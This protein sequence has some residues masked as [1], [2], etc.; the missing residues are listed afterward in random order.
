VSGTR[1]DDHGVARALRPLALRDEH[2]IAARK[3]EHRIALANGALHGDE[4]P[5]GER[6]QDL[7]DP[8]LAARAVERLRDAEVAHGRL[9]RLAEIGGKRGLI[10]GAARGQQDGGDEEGECQHRVGEALRAHQPGREAL[11][12]RGV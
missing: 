6:E 5:I 1:R 7:L 4:R 10:E 8:H 12:R 11:H 9:R 3:R 2:A